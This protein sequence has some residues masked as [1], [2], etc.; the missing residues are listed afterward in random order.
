MNTKNVLKGNHALWLLFSI[1]S[2]DYGAA[3]VEKLSLYSTC[4]GSTVSF[5]SAKK[6]KP[7][8]YSCETNFIEVRMQINLQHLVLV[9][10]SVVI[11][12]VLVRVLSSLCYWSLIG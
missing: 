10:V 9:F 2:S 5:G 12:L 1:K 6:K 11:R 4:T 8:M 3:T 7:P